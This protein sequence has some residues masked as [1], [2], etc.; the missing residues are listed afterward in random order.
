M[1]GD[2]WSFNASLSR[3]KQSATSFW[4]PVCSSS[5]LRSSVCSCLKLVALVLRKLL[6]KINEII[7]TVLVWVSGQ[8]LHVQRSVENDG[9]RVRVSFHFNWRSAVV[10]VLFLTVGFCLGQGG[11]ISTTTTTT[12][13]DRGL[14]K[15]LG[16]E[17]SSISTMLAKPCW[18]Y[19]PSRPLKDGPGKHL[20]HLRHLRI[21]DADF[22]VYCVVLKAAVR[23]DRLASRG[24]GPHSQLS[25]DDRLFLF[26]IHYRHRLLHGQHLRRF[27]YRHFPERGRAGV[28]QLRTRQKSGT[29]LLLSVRPHLT[30]KRLQIWKS[31]KWQP[32]LKSSKTAEN[33]LGFLKF[34]VFNWF[35]WIF[36]IFASFLPCTA[37]LIKAHCQIPR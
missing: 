19:L 29:F 32:P 13:I 31:F 1:L 35:F 28:P 18:L 12:S 14:L 24:H 3:W 6:L 2:S 34:L 22:L 23:F 37:P 8:I 33:D 30:Q 27:R 10:S 17:T 20:R 21:S 4:S 5:C 9:R 11:P 36:W 25:T 16:K 7:I 15:E 26:H